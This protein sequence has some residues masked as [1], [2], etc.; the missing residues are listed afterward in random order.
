[1]NGPRAAR[2]PPRVQPAVVWGPPYR[3]SALDGHALNGPQLLE[4]VQIPLGMGQRADVVF[5]MPASGAVRLAG[6]KGESPLLPFGASRATASVIIG[7]GEAPA[8]VDASSLPRFDLT[9]YGRPAADLIAEAARF[10]LTR[11]IVLGAAPAFR[12]G[13]FDYAQTFDGHASPLV[14]PI[15]VRGGELVHLQI[16]NPDASSTHP[17]HIHGHVFSVLALN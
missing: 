15:R 10:D 12:N 5:T 8:T 16:V 6:I 2:S 17:I 7:A 9:R 3:I 4:P 11:R 14:P 13:G 1:T